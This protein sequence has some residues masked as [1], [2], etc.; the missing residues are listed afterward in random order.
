MANFVTRNIPTNPAQQ[1]WRTTTFLYVSAAASD[2][3][4]RNSVHC[5]DRVFVYSDVQFYAKANI[6]STFNCMISDTIMTVNT[7]LRFH[8]I[9]CL[10]NGR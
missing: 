1:P 7:N 3:I 10:E 9:D 5:L 2:H 4:Q 8:L 6:L